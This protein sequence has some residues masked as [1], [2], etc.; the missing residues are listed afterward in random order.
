MEIQEKDKEGRSDLWADE[1]TDFFCNIKWTRP[2][3]TLLDFILCVANDSLPF[4]VEDMLPSINEKSD[5]HTN[6]GLEI[7]LIK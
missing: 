5:Y 3:F 6:Y 1:L 7:Q 4:W 2:R